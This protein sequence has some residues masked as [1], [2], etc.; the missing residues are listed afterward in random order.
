MS[1]EQEV[2][3]IPEPFIEIDNTITCED[4]PKSDVCEILKSV[5]RLGMAIQGIQQ[6]Y[7]VKVTLI[8]TI[9]DCQHKPEIALM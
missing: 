5:T 2:V 6:D 4:C 9:T 7:K 3:D 1:S 8:A